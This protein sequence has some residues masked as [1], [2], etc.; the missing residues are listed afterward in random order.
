MIIE[1]VAVEL[2]RVKL[3]TVEVDTEH[4][5]P[6]VGMREVSAS[7]TRDQNRLQQLAKN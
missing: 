2:L 5:R 3:S 4:F 6:G 1:S 7:V